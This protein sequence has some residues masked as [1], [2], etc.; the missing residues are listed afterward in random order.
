MIEKQ[1]EMTDRKIW[2]SGEVQADVGDPFKK[3]TH[4]VEAALNR[5]LQGVPFGGK[6]EDWTFIAIIRQEDHPY[7]DEVVRKSAKGKTLEFRLKIPHEEFSSA[8][9]DGQI[10]LILQALSRSVTLMGK[11]GISVEAQNAL[12]TALFRA[13]Q[14]LTGPSL[15]T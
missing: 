4:P 9:P 14:E 5:L 6:V 7:Y 11:L 10:R 15:R 2:I 13:E 8:S 12:Q 3:A 1:Q